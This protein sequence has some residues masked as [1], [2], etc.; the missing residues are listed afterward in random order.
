MHILH[1]RLALARHIEESIGLSQVSAFFLSSVALLEHLVTVQVG[2][3]LVSLNFSFDVLLESS[4]V[5]D[6]GFLHETGS[7]GMLIAPC[8]S[9]V[10]DAGAYVLESALIQELLSVLEGNNK[11][12]R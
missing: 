5:L 12:T 9:G 11:H 10:S 3:C 2:V 8:F 1:V 7:T 6:N 4:Q